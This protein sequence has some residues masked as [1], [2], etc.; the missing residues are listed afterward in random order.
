MFRFKQFTIH[1]DRTAMKVGTDGVLLGA[2]ASLD[3]EESNILDIG[4]GTAL[5]ALMM[6][7]RNPLSHIDAIEIDEASADQAAENIAASPWRDRISLYKCAVQEFE[8]HR[9]YDLIVSNPPFFCNSLL[10]PKAER[11][12]ARHTITLSFEDLLFAVE[13]LLS[14]GG[15]FALILPY[16]EFKLFEKEAITKFTLTKICNVKSFDDS[17]AIR[18]MSE[19]K[20]ASTTE[21]VHQIFRESLAIRDRVSGDYSA[22]YRQITADFYLKF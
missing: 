11:S 5:I 3:G 22:K 15:R 20:F 9:K 17:E 13:R 1:Q 21:L 19:W 12:A 7:Q 18:V 6:A 2:W 4:A 8:S 10:P 16:S 14:D